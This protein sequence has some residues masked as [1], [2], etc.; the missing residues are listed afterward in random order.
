MSADIPDGFILDGKYNQDGRKFS[1]PISYIYIWH[2]RILEQNL[3]KQSRD[4]KC[5]RQFKE[6]L[7]FY[8]VH[9]VHMPLSNILLHC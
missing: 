7:E 3:Q 4:L 2:K 5:S 6:S 8:N 1:I 9:I